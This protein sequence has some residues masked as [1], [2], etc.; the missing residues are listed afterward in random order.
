MSDEAQNENYEKI[1]IESKVATEDF[2]SPQAL[3]DWITTE[4]SIWE[5]LIADANPLPSDQVHNL[6][7][8]GAQEHASDYRSYLGSLTPENFSDSRDLIAASVRICQDISQR[9]D[10]RSLILS[11]SHQG[12]RVRALAATDGP[13]ANLLIGLYSGRNITRVTSPQNLKELWRGL[14]RII[15]GAGDG[16]IATRAED[17]D[18][19]LSD[20]RSKASSAAHTESEIS[21][22]LARTRAESESRQQHADMELR[23]ALNAAKNS[24]TETVKSIQDE[25]TA[26]RALYD[27]KFAFQA[28]V[29]YWSKRRKIHRIGSMVWGAASAGFAAFLAFVL[30]PLGSEKFKAAQ[31]LL[32]EEKITPSF[33]NYLPEIFIVAVLAFIC[34]WTLRFFV[35]QVSEHLARGEEASQRITMAET[36]LA[37]ANPQN[38]REALVGEAD[39]AVIVQALF[40]ASAHYGI[41]DAPPAHWIEDVFRRIKEK[42]KP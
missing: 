39:R 23:E 22:L 36:F 17:A 42:E 13:A 21:D 11:T 9:L 32:N 29:A 34:L 40:R 38:G 20:L 5:G 8:Q 27:S 6:G 28:P 15:T 18:R 19:F 30:V 16:D 26:L 12:I 41:D 7:L 35:R 1:R 3:I 14:A 33:L 4:A 25:W 24:S 10:E 37:L 31:A 2:G